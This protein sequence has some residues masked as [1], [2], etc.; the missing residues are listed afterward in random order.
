MT[1]IPSRTPPAPPGPDEHHPVRAGFLASLDA[2]RG[3]LHA[4]TAPASQLEEPG[5]SAVGPLSWLSDGRHVVFSAL[6]GSVQDDQLRSLDVTGTGTDLMA[7]SQALFT[8]DRSEECDSL[9]ITPDGGTVICPA[10]AGSPGDPGAGCAHGA[11]RFTAFPL[12]DEPSGKPSR[13]LYQYPGTCNNAAAY[14]MWTDASASSIIGEM[15]ITS[16]S[17]KTVFQLGAIFGGHIRPL[18]IAKSVNPGSY[19]AF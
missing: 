2:H 4:W 9:L 13:V 8:A 11:L 16:K 10:L 1:R 19:F 17:G 7:G 15:T 5:G 3:Q 18:N 12:P 14:L 6:A